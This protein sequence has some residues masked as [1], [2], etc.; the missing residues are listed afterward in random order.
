[1]DL[2]SYYLIFLGRSVSGI[3][4]LAKPQPGPAPR[5][6]VPVPLSPAYRCVGARIRIAKGLI[7]GKYVSFNG[8]LMTLRDGQIECR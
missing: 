6:L 8:E 3:T 1:M 5:D 4:R 7:Y 2:T